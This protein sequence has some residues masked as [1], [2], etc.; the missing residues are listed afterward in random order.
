MFDDDQNQGNNNGRGPQKPPG[1][2]KVPTTTWLA[3]IV[4]IGS[5]GALMLVH[6]RMG[7]QTGTIS[8]P[9]F[10]QKFESNQ[11]VSAVI[12][13]NPQSA[14]LTQITGKYY[15]TEKDGSISK[16]PVEVPFLS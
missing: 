5:I 6:Q 13:Y 15:K 3:W 2:L 16:P 10:L 4:I 1:G 11:I 12:S 8:E 14:P 9:E 7:V